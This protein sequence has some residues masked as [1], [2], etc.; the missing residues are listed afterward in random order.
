MKMLSDYIKGL[1][2]FL[3]KNG[4]MPCIYSSDDEG[5][6]HQHVYYNGSLAYAVGIEEYRPSIYCVEDYDNGEI[7]PEDNPV[8]VCIIN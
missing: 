4:D 8:K 7:E 5:N 1:Q 3:E 2:E 6:D